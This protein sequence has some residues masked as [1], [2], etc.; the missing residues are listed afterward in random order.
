MLKLQKLIQ[1]SKFNGRKWVLRLN[2]IIVHSRSSGLEGLF[3]FK[4]HEAEVIKK[5]KKIF[6]PNIFLTTL[7][8]NKRQRV[9]TKKTKK[10]PIAP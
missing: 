1:L 8:M 2:S 7:K 3:N 9:Y 4:V 6:I 5:K 10:N